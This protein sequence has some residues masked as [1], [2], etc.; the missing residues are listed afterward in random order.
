MIDKLSL[1]GLPDVDEMNEFTE[2]ADAFMEKA[3]ELA[4]FIADWKPV[5]DAV[6]ELQ[7][8]S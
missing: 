7:Q 5:L 6:S 3:N 4:Q 8:T 1:D 2:A